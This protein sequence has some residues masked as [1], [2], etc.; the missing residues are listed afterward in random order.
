MSSSESFNFNTVV[1]PT[2]WLVEDIIP[3][4]QLIFCLAR[5]GQG[6]SYFIESLA[7]NIIFATDFLGKAT[8]P[9]DV[10]LID[11]DTP[12]DTLKARLI[13]FGQ[14]NGM[15]PKFDLYLRSHEGLS[16]S[17]KSLLEVVKE[18]PTAILIIID[19]YHSVAGS[20]DTSSTN[21]VNHA[22]TQ[23]KRMLTP[24]RTIWV[25]HHI[26][27]KKLVSLQDM[28]FG[29]N[30]GDLFMGNSAV[31]QQLD[32]AFIVNGQSNNG[33]LQELYIRP[34]G[35]RTYIPQAPFL[36]KFIDNSFVYEGDL[37]DASNQDECVCDL[38]ILFTEYPFEGFTVKGAHEAM[39]QKHGWVRLRQAL[40]HMEQT[41][42]S[43]MER[44]S[45]NQFRYYP[46]DITKKPRVIVSS[47]YLKEKEHK[48][49]EESEND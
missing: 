4:G 38:R 40:A 35:K 45:C 9:G 2:K 31:V 39:G 16:M 1:P 48:E 21:D 29:S 23:L 7:T 44:G 19:S 22:C 30:I 8:I 15:K 49:H 33:L 36:A 43:R 13:S 25:N 14:T 42:E 3:L 46:T 26:S 6:K 17:N 41:G 20:M 11:Q 37:E 12:Q 24:D 18:Y 5:A 10:L 27:E 32:S 34:W 47:L 28:M